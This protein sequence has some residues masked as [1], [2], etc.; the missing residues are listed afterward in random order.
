MPA[1]A[2]LRNWI[3]LS[4][5]ICFFGPRRA[6]HWLGGGKDGA[7]HPKKPMKD[8]QVSRT[9]LVMSLMRGIHTRFDHPALIDDTWAERFVPD[10]ERAAILSSRGVRVED[11]ESLNAAL[12]AA[13]PKS[14]AYPS[15]ILRTR[16]TE[17]ALQAAIANGICQYVIIGAGMDSFALRRPD[18]AKGVQVIE[19][20]H[21]ATQSFKR[22]RLRVA[23]VE[24]PPTLDFVAVD[25][26]TNDLGTA[27]KRS[28]YRKDRLAFFSWLG[29]TMYLTRDANLATLKAIAGCSAPGSELAF[30]YIDQREFDPI[31]QSKESKSVQSTVGALGEVWISGFDPAELGADLR[32]VGFTLEED[33]DGEQISKRYYGNS[34]DALRPLA[35]NHYARA[36][37]AAESHAR[38]A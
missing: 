15:A 18:F 27:L 24:I 16:W 22:E 32:S 26:S 21:P 34:K 29:V 12:A 28:T 38:A 4:T 6:A 2:Y 19:V 7:S 10:T 13:L 30:S 1:D 11:F 35:T 31:L 17:D 23:E 37:V 3:F 33:I 36:R 20:D 14:P 25:L 8:A 5:G 9:S